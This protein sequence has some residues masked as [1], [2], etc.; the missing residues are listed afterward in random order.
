[1]LD[2]EVIAMKLRGSANDALDVED[3]V[4]EGLGEVN[5]EVAFGEGDG[6]GVGELLACSE[7]RKKFVPKAI[8]ATIETNRTNK[9]KAIILLFILH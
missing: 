4:G 8:I 6:L 3:E 5:C 9:A 7:I 1:V 2:G